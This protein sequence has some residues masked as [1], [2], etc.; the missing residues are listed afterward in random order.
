[1]PDVFV[2][3][4]TSNNSAYFNKLYAKNV[5]ISFTL[6][7]YDKNRTFLNEQYKSFNDFKT[8]F[9]FTPD[10]IKSLIAR[11]EAE[12]VKYNEDQFNKSRKEILLIL[13][14]YIASNMWQT[15]ELYQVVNENDKVID[16]ALKVI[17]DKSTYNYILGNK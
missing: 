7:Y 15:S 6:D 11:G 3:A 13:K 17:S 9:E 2:S 14:G 12:G 8:K 16:K 4:D 5:L 10:Q 1:M